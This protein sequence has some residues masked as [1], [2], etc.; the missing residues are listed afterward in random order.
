MMDIGMHW[1]KIGLPININTYIQI[2]LDN[3]HNTEP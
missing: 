3:G 2:A 1:T